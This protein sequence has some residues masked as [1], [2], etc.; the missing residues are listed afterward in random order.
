MRATLSGHGVR[1]VARRR[2]DAGQPGWRF[3]SARSPSSV[4]LRGGCTRRSSARPR[5]IDGRKRMG[6][7]ALD[8]VPLT[9]QRLSHAA[10]STSASRLRA[11]CSAHR[12]VRASA[13]LICRAELQVERGFDARR[14]SCLSV[15]RSR[16]SLAQELSLRSACP[17]APLCC[18]LEL[19]P[20]LST[21]SHA[22]TAQL[23]LATTSTDAARP[24]ADLTSADAT[25]HSAR[26]DHSSRSGTTS[27][28]G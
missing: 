6:A 25:D 8:V 18:N 17:W 7:I 16:C 10:A 24:W 3:C 15:S 4:P 28:R 12:L 1:Q 2:S 14:P 20:P 23:R 5:R 27:G 26:R 19:H 22:H 13:A 11:T 9:R 21:C